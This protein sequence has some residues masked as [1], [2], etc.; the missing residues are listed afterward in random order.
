MFSL[1]RLLKIGVNAIKI[2]TI[3]NTSDDIKMQSSCTILNNEKTKD[4]S[5]QFLR[6]AGPVTIYQNLKSTNYDA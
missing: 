2:M 6:F 1:A 5:L 3:N 4:Q